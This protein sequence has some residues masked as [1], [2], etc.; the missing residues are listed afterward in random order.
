MEGVPPSGIRTKPENVQ[1]GSVH[2][3]ATYALT[4]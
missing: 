1:A 4:R 3:S 2:I